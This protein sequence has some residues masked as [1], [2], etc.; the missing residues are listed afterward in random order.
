M[1]GDRGPKATPEI[2]RLVRELSK[3]AGYFVTHS[4]L[5]LARDK[6]FSALEYA[7]WITAQM[8]LLSETIKFTPAPAS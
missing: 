7:L 4:I 2:R 1:G 5:S 6:E 3:T 8:I